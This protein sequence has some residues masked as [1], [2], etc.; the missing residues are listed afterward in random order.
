MGAIASSIGSVLN[1]GTTAFGIDQANRQQQQGYSNAN[2]IINQYY[3]EAR[4][5]I[6]TGY[7]NAQTNFNNQYTAAGN[8]LANAYPIATNTLQ[9]YG[10][11]ANTSNNALSGLIT[12]GYGT[13]QF[14]NQDLNAQMAPN[15]A[16][17]LDQGQRNAAAMANQAGGQLSGN[18][19]QGLNTF[20]QNFAANAYQN[21]FNNFNT[22]RN[23]IF[24][25]ITGVSQMAA[26]PTTALANLQAGYGSAQSNLLANQGS[27]LANMNIGQGQSL[28]S[29]YTGQ[30][31]LLAG[32]NINAGNAAANSTN[33]LYGSIGQGFQGA[34]DSYGGGGTP[35]VNSIMNSRGFSGSGNFNLPLRT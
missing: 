25:N 11:L 14:N 5:Q 24:S 27:N 12:S 32:N 18:A 30:G 15:Y 21:A 22:Q 35:S 4:N 9:S 31:N 33:A 8:A 10:D 7:N 28:A 16:F 17:Q 19:L 2:G 6:N 3:P 34:G 20:T 29:L 26:A 1:A 13:R 23:N